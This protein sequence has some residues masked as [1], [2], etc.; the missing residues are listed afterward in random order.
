[1]KKKAIRV[2]I[3]NNYYCK[4][5]IIEHNGFIALIDTNTGIKN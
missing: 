5:M 4:S 1:M 2:I 3:I